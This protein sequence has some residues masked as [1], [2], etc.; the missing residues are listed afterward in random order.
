MVDLPTPPLPLPTATTY[1]AGAGGLD[2]AG[3]GGATYSASQ[4]H[5]HLSHSYITLAAC[6]GPRG[7]LGARYDF[8][9]C[10]VTT[11]QFDWTGLRLQDETGA[12]LLHYRL[13]QIGSA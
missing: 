12:V 1:R 10:Q 2:R 7:N 9:F 13:T 3:S 11:Y 4:G 5:L 8:A 6:S